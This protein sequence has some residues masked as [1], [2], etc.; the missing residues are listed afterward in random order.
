MKT[1]KIP[2][3]RCIGCM[4]SKPKKELLRIVL[5][6]AG[7]VIPD[8]GGRANGRGAYLCPDPACLTAA[9]KRKAIQR[10]LEVNLTAEDLDVLMEEIGAYVQQNS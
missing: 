1:R 10:S 7:K 9:K 3:R 4:E 2:M 5:T 8:P 6:P